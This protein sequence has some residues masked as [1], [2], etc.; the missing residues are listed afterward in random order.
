MIRLSEDT[1]IKTKEG[2]LLKLL[3]NIKLRMLW[4]RIMLNIYQRAKQEYFN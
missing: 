3:L 4:L 2:Y 1:L